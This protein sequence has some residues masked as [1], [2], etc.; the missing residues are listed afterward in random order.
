MKIKY[1]LILVILIILPLSGC[2]TKKVN[3]SADGGVYKSTDFGSNWSHVVNVSG[4]KDLNS[5]KNVNVKFFVADPKKK[6]KIFVAIQNNGIFVTENG[7]KEWKATSRSLGNYTAL[8]IDSLN[9]NVIYLSDGSRILKTIDGMKT[10]HQIY[11]E[12]RPGQRINTII[13]DYYKSNI[14]YASTTTGIIK[15]TNYGDSWEL[16]DWTKPEINKLF[17]SRKNSNVLFIQ[18]G[19]DIYKSLDGAVTW[20]NVTSD[21]TTKTKNVNTIY[22]AD[23]NH[24]TEYIFLGTK[25]G[26]I[27]SLD[28]G[29]TWQ[30]LST[31]FD[32]KKQAI[33]SVVHNPFDPNEVMFSV[34]NIL[35]KTTDGGKT[36]QALKTVPTSRIINVLLA[37]PFTH[38]FVYLGTNKPAEKK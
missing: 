28:G 10:W 2:G 14:I 6:N 34:V 19:L 18:G 21:P 33:K 36:W 15:S 22:S 20:E 13:V 24:D 17:L 23:F 9:N 11:T 29:K 37:D 30:S 3:T 25:N 5:L 12:T 26:I 7:G 38:D 32:L 8:S 4:K 27:K 1:L 31:L 35:H 16:L